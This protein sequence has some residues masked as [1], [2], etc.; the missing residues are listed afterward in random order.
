MSLY[1]AIDANTRSRQTANRLTELSEGSLKQLEKQTHTLSSQTHYLSQQ[2]DEQ[3]T[4][5]RT[6][7]TQL[8]IVIENLRK[9]VTHLTEQTSSLSEL[10][11]QGKQQNVFAVQPFGWWRRDK[12]LLRDAAMQ[13]AANNTIHS[14]LYPWPA[15]QNAIAFLTDSG[16]S[17]PGLQLREP[18]IEDAEFHNPD[19]IFSDFSQTS[20][21]HVLFAPADRHS[22]IL[23]NDSRFR[24]SRLSNVKFDSTRLT[25]ADFRDMRMN[26][27][28]F[29]WSGLTKAD[30]SHALLTDVT[31]DT[32]QEHNVNFT[33]SG[34]TSVLFLCREKDT[35]CTSDLDFPDM[36]ALEAGLPFGWIDKHID[37]EDLHDWSAVLLSLSP[38]TDA[39]FRGAFLLNSRFS[40]NRHIIHL[41]NFARAQVAGTSFERQR[42][43]S[44]S[45]YKAQVINSSFQGALLSFINA[46]D[47]VFT[48]TSFADAQIQNVTFLRQCSRM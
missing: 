3:R 16:V 19:M 43:M 44:S 38:L 9:E 42:L 14:T 17:I 26:G 31:F 13:A 35:S 34:L 29:I 32:V 20:L 1:I 7:A 46:R 15:K 23:L 24:N 27:G 18:L 37:P 4:F 8:D 22:N 25:G 21:V 12:S 33:D 10:V 41:A 11:K 6:A 48:A 2:L 5:S 40:V 36:R 45:F 47:A 39:D 30:F 28:Q